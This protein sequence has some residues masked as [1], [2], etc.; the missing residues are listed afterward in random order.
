ML[1]CTIARQ[2]CNILSIL[3][4]VDGKSRRGAAGF[5]HRRCPFD[6]NVA[7]HQ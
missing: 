3:L 6:V 4:Q 1:Q 7:G 2:T 5:T